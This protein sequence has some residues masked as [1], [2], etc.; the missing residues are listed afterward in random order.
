M[1]INIINC[2]TDY[3]K[4]EFYSFI[5]W[6]RNKK[7]MSFYDKYFEDFVKKNSIPELS[8]AVADQIKNFWKKY[9]T[10]ETGLNYHRIAALKIPE[11]KLKYIVNDSVFNTFIITK[12]NPEN[13]AY[14]LSDKG[15]YNVFFSGVSRPNEIVRNVSG[16]FLDERNNII[17]RFIAVQKILQQS[18]P[19]VF[20]KSIDSCGGKNIKKIDVK[21]SNLIN[22]TFDLFKEDFVVQ[23]FL[24]QS[25]QTAR[26]NPTSLNTFR[27]LSLL[28]NGKFSILG[29]WLRC[30]TYGSVVDNLTSG[31]M[32][33]CVFP[34][35]KMSYGINLDVPKIE[36]SPTGLRFEDCQIEHFDRIVKLAEELHKRIP[37]MSMVGWDFALDI[38]DE[39]V[40][41]EANYI[42]PD[43]L[44]WQMTQ[45]PI[46]GDRLQEVLDFCFPNINIK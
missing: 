22:Q 36:R 11:E 4:R 40:F 16:V 23:E 38:N 39:P 7:Q 35:G 44:P 14:G 41:I 21:D 42:R 13:R 1:L 34:D 31:G 25:K 43:T 17:D 45:G 19:V 29:V 10:Y 46:F 37:S 9:T 18:N 26:F 2:I 32:A 6:R 20:K 8:P 15:L 5:I 28:L 12:L 24:V 27:V 3:I 33:A 30:G